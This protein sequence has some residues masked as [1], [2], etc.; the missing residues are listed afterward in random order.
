MRRV[1]WI[2]SHTGDLARM[3][4]LQTVQIRSLLIT[5]KIVPMQFMANFP[6]EVY[7]A[8]DLSANLNGK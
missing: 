5:S 8:D 1:Q 4:G 7:A 3:L 2:R 6:V